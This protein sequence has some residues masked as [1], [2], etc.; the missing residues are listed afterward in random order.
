MGKQ[1]ISNR[2]LATLLVV[3]IVISLGG[4]YLVMQNAPAITGLAIDANA[5]GTFDFQNEGFLTIHLDDNSA[6]FG[7]ITHTD[8]GIC[9]LNTAGPLYNSSNCNVAIPTA[10]GGN[11]ASQVMTVN[12]SGNLDANITVNFT[13]ESMDGALGT[14]GGFWVAANTGSNCRQADG[15]ADATEGVWEQIFDDSSDTYSITNLCENLSFTPA[16]GDQVTVDF[17][18]NVSDD[19]PTGQLGG[20]SGVEL[21]FKAIQFT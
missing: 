17:Y 5:S 7:N 6:N 13:S 18:M 20:G 16:N 9:E 14:Y 10:A 3:A 11:L 4:T 8:I 12:N 19:A 1:D 15:A 2:T 21:T